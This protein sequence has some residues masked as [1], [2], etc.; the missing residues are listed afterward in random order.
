MKVY[1][2]FA[3]I[4]LFSLLP[5]LSLVAN[6]GTLGIIEYLEGSLSLLRN[7]EA[8]D[9]D[10]GDSL[11]N[12]DLIRTGNDGFVVIKLDPASGMSGTLTVRPKTSC[13]LSTVIERGSPA[14]EAQTFAGSV[15]VK[16]KRISGDPSLRIRTGS[17]VMGVRG[18]EFQVQVSPNSGILVS[19]NE[20][21]VECQAE[22]N[23]RLDSVDA[24]PGQAVEY[25]EGERFKRIPVAVSSLE[26]FRERWGT[27]E[28]EAFKASALTVL[29]QY[30]RTYERYK[31]DYIKASE[32]LLALPAVQ[33]WVQEDKQGVV[34]HE[35]AVSVMGQKSTI[36]PRLMAVR[37]VLFFFEPAYYRLE[38]VREYLGPQHNS[39]QL[40]TGKTVR[41]FFL[42]MD[43]DLRGFEVLTSRYRQVLRLYALR[44]GGR[45]PFETTDSDS[46]GNSDESFFDNTD[47]FFN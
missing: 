9:A 2:G 16:V 46:F 12:Q 41:A 18:T 43:R 19:C 14:T 13:A 37:R 27:E 47:S 21:R 40:S 3:L 23:G 34:P 33:T 26:A 36:A 35:R 6:S 44:N 5:L 1:R 10:M 11:R 28:I 30:A 42:E 20:G 24:I 32:A 22:V 17:A 45:S 38:Q 8:L 25:R 31:A 39:H 29:D 15:A 7:G 4:A